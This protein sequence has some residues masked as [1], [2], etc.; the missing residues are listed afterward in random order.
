MKAV[1]INDAIKENRSESIIEIAREHKQV[2]FYAFAGRIL[3]MLDS[4]KRDM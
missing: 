1:M 4:W 3:H 2:N